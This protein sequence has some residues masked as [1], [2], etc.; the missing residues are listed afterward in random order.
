MTG[1]LAGEFVR[2]VGGD[3]GLASAALVIARLDCPQLD[4]TPYLRRLDEMGA[5]ARARLEAAQRSRRP[6][7]HEAVT[8]LNTYL[9]E[10]LR[11]SP[12]LDND[13]DP[14]NSFLNEV[15]DR[16]VGIPIALG[17]VYME[18]AR[19]AGIRIEGINFPGHF[20]LLCPGDSADELSSTGLVLDPFDAG[21]LLSER[22]CRDIL[23]ERLGNQVD[24]HPALLAPATR[25]QILVRLLVH[26]K[27]VYVGMRSFPQAREVAGLLVA[28]NPSASA[29][30]RD[31]G[32]LAYHLRDFPAALRDLETYLRLA[33]SEGLDP[34]DRE[35]HEQ[36]WEHV[37]T[38]RRRVASLN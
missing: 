2:A 35:E 18:V 27:R 22:E 9:F 32:L 19:R 1:D 13:D 10:E 16:G 34:D 3:E 8:A 24:F 28:I 11:L 36:I 14:R 17:V 15:L 7:R 20:L 4:P 21:A 31:R 26:L 38:L 25:Q 5:A 30:L 33:K 29:E 6:S 37:K 23:E 12:N